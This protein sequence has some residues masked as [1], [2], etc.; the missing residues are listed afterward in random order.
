MKTLGAWIAGIFALGLALGSFVPGS[1]AGSQPAT[2]DPP[3]HQVDCGEGREAL[4]EPG[5][6]DGTTLFKVRCVEIDDHR[7]THVASHPAPRAPAPV[8][9]AAPAPPPSGKCPCLSR[10]SSR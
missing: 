6:G 4:L 5:D 7:Q 9:A 8:V 1:G 3:L 10:P 2:S